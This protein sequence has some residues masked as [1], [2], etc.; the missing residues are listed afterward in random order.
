MLTPYLLVLSA[1]LMISSLSYLLAD[2]RVLVLDTGQQQQQQQ[3]TITDEFSSHSTTSVSGANI[4]RPPKQMQSHTLTRR[5]A[6]STTLADSFSLSNLLTQLDTLAWLW[7]CKTNRTLNIPLA[8]R[9]I[10]ESIQ[11]WVKL[12]EHNNDDTNEEHKT[13]DRRM[14]KEKTKLADDINPYDSTTADNIT[15]HMQGHSNAAQ[16]Q[17]VLLITLA[18]LY[19]KHPYIVA[20][21]K[22]LFPNITI[23]N[24]PLV[25][26]VDDSPAFA[27]RLTCDNAIPHWV[28]IA[29]Y[30]TTNA[31]SF[32][33]VQLPRELELDACS[34]S[35]CQTHC[36]YSIHGGVRVFAR[37]CCSLEERQ[38][39]KRLEKGG[40][41]DDELWGDDELCRDDWVLL[42]RIFFIASI[43][44]MLL[45][46]FMIGIVIRE[47]R[48]QQHDRGWTLMEPFFAGAIILY[49]IPL[50]GWPH[51]FPWSCWFA[52]VARQIGFVFFYGSVIL[53]IYRNLQEYRVRKAQHV[54]V[55][56]LDLVTYLLFAF[57]IVCYGILA[58]STGAFNRPELWSADWPQCSME[59]FTVLFSIF[60]LLF[61]LYGIRLSLSARNSSWIERYQFTMA[62]ILEAV[63]SLIANA[64]R[65]TLDGVSSRDTL[66]LIAVIQLHLTIS[67]NI[68]AIITPKFLVSS[69]GNRRTMGNTT[70][71]GSSGRAHPSLAKM[72]ENLIN[73][74]IDFQEVPIVDMNPEDIRAEL[75]RV[76]TQLRMFKLKN[77]YQ[78]NPH[79][80]KRKGGGAKKIQLQTA[81][82]TP[83]A[84]GC[85]ETTSGTATTS[86][87]NCGTKSRAGSAAVVTTM[88]VDNR[89]I[90]QQQAANAFAVFSNSPRIRKD[91]QQE[92]T[93]AAISC[94]SD[95][96]QTLLENEEEKSD[97]TVES[98]PHNIL[99]TSK[100]IPP[101]VS[102]LNATDQS[103][104]V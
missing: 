101:N 13:L 37:S 98:A 14:G 102:V 3:A 39:G 103:I 90:S 86:K 11:R 36:S 83:T 48:R 17:T 27:F 4:F 45:C 25:R 59:Q 89:R 97:L 29:V 6:T 41:G 47:R 9:L 104:R 10:N 56:E 49:S 71:M 84:T 88:A 91:N 58:W 15:L 34:H 76:Y 24:Q 74:T 46:F 87:P 51:H 7:P 53:K 77:A 61:L 80:S 72:R 99:L 16:Q 92:R 62:V 20:P 19:S 60:E 93:S 94:G 55:R 66:F 42:Q 70:G 73:G 78:D 1:A 43:I 38:R 33:Q 69:E 100:L 79:I 63:V 95:C 64:I 12:T 75:K 81:T 96:R 44:C 40:G 52:I 68:A 30:P 8:R 65:Y 35:Q 21:K 32:L 22:T 50:L 23:T 85:N 31:H 26:P 57:S 54:T 67:V 82:T 2:A 28:P 5:H 18:Q